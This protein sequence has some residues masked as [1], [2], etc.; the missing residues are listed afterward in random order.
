MS[1][2]V[3]V[4][5]AADC[6]SARQSKAID[7]VP[8]AR[9]NIGVINLDRFISSPYLPFPSIKVDAYGY[10]DR[11]FAKEAP[12]ICRTSSWAKRVGW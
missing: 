1:V 3:I 12:P 2:V 9:F 4:C 5:A 6:A 10:S 8:N 7:G 11:I